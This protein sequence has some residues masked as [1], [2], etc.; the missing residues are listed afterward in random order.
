VWI[1]INSFITGSRVQSHL[2]LSCEQW[3]SMEEWMLG[4]WLIISKADTVF[5]AYKLFFPTT[6][7]YIM[8]FLDERHA[9]NY[10]II[11]LANTIRRVGSH[12]SSTR[13]RALR[14][15][16]AL[17]SEP[18]RALQNKQKLW[19]T[20]GI[21]RKTNLPYGYTSWKLKIMSWNRLGYVMLVLWVQ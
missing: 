9:P 20:F 2:A 10:N 8:N 18:S 1:W 4:A 13:L 11:T 12:C 3:A 15:A 19:R 5:W 7:A 17:G 21:L 14:T 6:S 16:Q